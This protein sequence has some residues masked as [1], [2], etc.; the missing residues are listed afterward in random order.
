[1]HLD[2]QHVVT[3]HQHSTGRSRDQPMLQQA[4]LA[5]SP[6]ERRP[7]LPG[8]DVLPGDLHAVQVRDEAVVII[9][10]E[11]QLAE[12][13][14]VD[15][16]REVSAR[17]QGHLA[18]HRDRGHQYAGAVAD[19]LITRRPARVVERPKLPIGGGH[20]I[21]HEV[22]QRTR[23]DHQGR[24][25]LI[26]SL[27][28]GRRDVSRAITD[29]RRPDGIAAVHV[30]PG[31]ERHGARVA[32]QPRRHHRDLRRDRI[33]QH[34]LRAGGP[35]ARQHRLVERQSHLRRRVRASRDDARRRGIRALGE[36]EE[37]H[38]D[39]VIAQEIAMQ[40]VARDVDHARP[41]DVARLKRHQR[42]RGVRQGA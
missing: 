11:H 1:M 13:G 23:G 5:R 2:G 29:A 18:A 34:P 8:R 7:A 24:N 20:A 9:D 21:G 14:R 19:R 36:P 41:D 35:V 37:I 30:Q 39:A 27:H 33:R 40:R 28:A 26:R 6:G 16:H 17:V 38:R 32:A 12:P 22:A 42:M 10:L 3:C 25:H 4:S 31:V 15:R